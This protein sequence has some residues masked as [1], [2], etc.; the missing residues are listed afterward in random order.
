MSHQNN[1]SVSEENSL[2]IVWLDVTGFSKAIF[3][4]VVSA[5]IWGDYLKVSDQEY[6][7]SRVEIQKLYDVFRKGYLE[8]KNAGS[9]TYRTK[10]LYSI[11]QTKH[12]LNKVRKKRTNAAVYM[13]YLAKGDIPFF[14]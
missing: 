5:G 1:L 3:G 8:A 6:Q 14:D 2:G 11:L 13:E 12:N 4:E 9:L 7:T 10:M